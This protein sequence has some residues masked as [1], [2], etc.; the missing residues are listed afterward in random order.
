MLRQILALTWKDLKVFFKDRGAVVMIFVQPFMFILVM[1]YALS[2]L[3][4]T[5]DRPIQILTVNQ[6][7][8]TQA[9]AILRQLDEIKAFA[10]ETTWEGQLL[11]HQKAEQLIIKGKRKLALIFPPDFSAMLEQDLAAQERRTTRVLFIVEPTTSSQFVEPIL[12]TLQGLLERTAYAVMIPKRMDFLFDRLAPQ[13]TA[14]E[15]ERFRTR[16]GGAMSGGL[17]EGQT[18][19]VTV[20]RTTPPGMRVKKLPDTFQQNVPGY[21]IYGIFWIVNLLAVSV[22]REKREGTFRRLLVA[23]MGRMVMLAGKLMPYYLIN[24]IQIAI[25]LGVCG[26]LFKMSLWDSP[27]GLAVVSLAAAATATGLGVLVAALARTEAQIGGLTVLLLLTLSAL[28]GCF[29]PR[30]IMPDWLQ[31][32]G[33]VTPHAWALDA[34]QDLLVRGYGLIEILPKVGVL[35]AFAVVF[36]GIGVWRFRFE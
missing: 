30:F 24:I 31:T 35:A 27:A 8:G 22:L 1:S 25:M 18:P 13:T 32:V 6:D 12:G 33:L 15:R 7:K 4:R 36:F 23:P 9:A 26:L 11:T 28:G 16:A 10:V 2:G 21:T 14:I 5:G 20:E 29:I 19:V 3:Y 17:I 34:Y